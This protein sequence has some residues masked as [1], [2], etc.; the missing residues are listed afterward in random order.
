MS[1]RLTLALEE[2]FAPASDGVICVL[3]PRS[4]TSLAALP[5]ERVLVVQP[6]RPDHDHFAA[7]GYRCVAELPEAE[8]FAASL[9]FVTRTRAL[10][11]DLVARAAN[12]TDGVVLV[13]GAKTDGIDSL[14]KELKKH[15]SLT[16][17]IAKAH[18]KTAWFDAQTA[19]LSALQV[20]PFQTVDGFTTSPGIF[21]ADGVDAGSALLR[22]ALPE[23]LGKVVADFGA[24][25]GYLSAD[26]LRREKIET[27]HLVEADHRALTSARR[28]AADERA[29]YHWADV[30]KWQAPEPLDAV[31][32]NPPFHTTRKAEPSLG[33]A[34]IDS[35][36]RSLAPQGQLWMVANRHLPYEEHL[37][38]RF[39]RV[40]EI[41][42]DNRFK[43][44]H[45]Q[46]P[47]RKSR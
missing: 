38:A 15:A 11:R 42:G 6:F 13:D 27:L 8:R 32:M 12:Q 36:A 14:L 41:G 2:G 34:F 24:G 26:L 33:Q 10:N 44:L 22:A 39:A 45:A 35:A 19:D 37:T 7:Q 21:S 40:D 28:N 25:W 4:D 18:G 9:V 16:P 3:C 47:R 46:R 29:Q 31:I 30:T 20:A 1:I 43:L 17:A 23:K 5:Q